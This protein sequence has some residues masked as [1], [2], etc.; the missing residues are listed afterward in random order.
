MSSSSG[1]RQT[2]HSRF[3]PVALATSTSLLYMTSPQMGERLVLQLPKLASPR[4]R[5]SPTANMDPQPASPGRRLSPLTG[6]PLCVARPWGNREG[7]THHVNLS[8]RACRGLRQILW[9]QDRLD[10]VA[11]GHGLAHWLSTILEVQ[12]GRTTL[13]SRWG[14]PRASQW[15]ALSCC[16]TG[17]PVDTSGQPLR[18]EKATGVGTL[19]A[20]PLMWACW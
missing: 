7:A 17:S 18:E 12:G 20:L 3:R 2:S 9:G 1:R 16:Q 13:T 11:G 5:I 19:L 8:P 14:Q 4:G 10:P 15:H 6:Q